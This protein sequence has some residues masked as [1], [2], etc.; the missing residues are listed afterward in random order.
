M[1]IKKFVSITL[2]FVTFS[3][4]SQDHLYSSLTID[5][6][7]K[8]NANAVVRLNDIN[9]EIIS[10]N[11]MIIKQKR[12]VT[13][14]NEKGNRHLQAAVGYDNYRKIKKIEAFIFNE[15]GKEIKK[16]KKRD[17]I[18]HSAVDGGTL[19]SDSRVLFMAYTP[20]M[21]P[22]TVKFYYEVETP[23]TAAL[24]SWH[25]VEGY[26]LSIEQNV[27]TV[28]D[29]ANLGLRFKDF[30]FK[31]YQ[32]EKE[33]TATLLKY[34]ITNISAIKPEDLS[35]SLIDF[36]PHSKLAVKRFHFNGVDG[37][38]KNWLEFGDWIQNSLL[39]GRSEV[40]QKTKLQILD[41]VSGVEDTIERAKKVYQ[42]VQDNTRYIS[43]QVGIGGIQPIPA[44]EV[45]QLKYGDCKGLTIYTQSL[46]D[47]AGVTSYYTVVEAGKDIV[48]FDEDFASLE[49]GNHIILGIPNDD[50][51]VWLDCTTQI[52]PFGFIGDFTDNRNVLV[53]KPNASKIL[54]TTLYPD[55]LN[56][57]KTKASININSDTSMDSEITIKTKGI[58]Y[59]NRFF[60][61]RESKKNIIKH[62]KNY[63]SNVN[64]LEVLKYA[65]NND[66]NEVEF[67]ET[68]NIFA[69]N[70]ASLTGER[71]IFSPNAF[72]KNTFIPNRYRNRKLKIEIQRGYLD[73]DN[74]QI[75][76]PE[77]YEIEALPKNISIKNKFGE[78]V[79][80]IENVNNKIIYSRK[81]LINKGDYPKE[82]YESYRDFRKK[83]FKLDNS[84][85]VLKKIT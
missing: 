36:T 73:E 12:I 20:I 17:F 16:I 76:I 48:D 59:D 13:V 85:I 29:Y 61:E 19:Y 11:K 40:S 53:V 1:N 33:N 4:F 60:I 24:P 80:Q 49:Q 75:T 83:V 47:I 57:Q 22:Y 26:F 54:K 31:N 81:L 14:L 5:S 69:K 68:V 56:H 62:Y 27:F 58:Q 44:I 74:F 51:M 8:K 63:W 7:L 37:Q 28:N 55:N 46:L 41:L 71:F 30:S 10:Q 2:L 64:N 78:Y 39:Q 18:D 77:G 82:E 67:T 6:E 50:D 65:F 23:N 9:I 42:Y 38:A 70:Y 21:Y 79:I 35:P 32:I 34:S 3:I 15:S 52:Q 72:N 66:K 43:V 45:D 25:P 84:K